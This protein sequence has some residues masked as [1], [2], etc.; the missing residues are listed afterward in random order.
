MLTARSPK[1]P[2]NF[3]MALL[4]VFL[5]P[6]MRDRDIGEIQHT[7]PPNRDYANGLS[8]TEELFLRQE[9][10]GPD[11]GAVDSQRMNRL[12][13]STLELGYPLV[14][15]L[16][17]MIDQVLLSIKILTYIPSSAPIHA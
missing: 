3:E 16:F 17:P 15:E 11:R 13:E 8:W 2:K 9:L 7:T 5:K 10:F 12:F 1:D 4:F 14:G 6:V